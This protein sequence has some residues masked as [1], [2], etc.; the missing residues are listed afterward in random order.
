MTLREQSADL[1]TIFQAYHPRY[2]LD[3]FLNNNTVKRLSRGKVIRGGIE[4]QNYIRSVGD[5]THDLENGV[6]RIS[7]NCQNVNSELGFDLASNLRLLDYAVANYGKSYQSVRN[8]ALLVDLPEVFRGVLADGR[9]SDTVFQVEFIVDYESLGRIISS[10][11][12]SPRCPWVYKNGIECTSPSLLPT[13]PKHREGCVLRDAEKDFGGWEYFEQPSSAAPGSGTGIGGNPCFLGDT[14]VST[15]DGEIPIR[16]MQARLDE[17]KNSVFSFDYKTG[18]IIEDEIEKVWV[19]RATGYFSFEFEFGRLD[20]TPSHKL[21]RDFGV[22]KAA[23]DFERGKDSVKYLSGK[24]L[25]DSKLL[26]IKWNSDVE[27]TV[28]NLRVKKNRTYFANRFAVSNAKQVEP[29][30]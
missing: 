20:V 7:I 1:T 22:W 2:T 8:P 27:N 11:N 17:G 9:V 12:L 24:N 5:L 4:Y 13:C 23:N 28:F 6:D 26:K 14:P 29:I 3:L 30:I 25:T 19:H 10:R 21:L 15:P 16:E 18:E